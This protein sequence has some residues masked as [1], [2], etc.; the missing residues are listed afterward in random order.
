MVGSPGG[1][2]QKGAPASAAVVAFVLL[3]SLINKFPPQS[4]MLNVG[5]DVK[6]PPPQVPEQ[7]KTAAAEDGGRSRLLPEGVVVALTI[8][9]PLF[10]ILAPSLV[11]DGSS[12]QLVRSLDT[13]ETWKLLSCHLVGQTG[14]YGT[15]EII[16]S[17]L[18][19]PEK[20]FFEKCSL[21]SE[22]CLHLV[23]KRDVVLA[24][25]AAGADAAAAAT[26]TPVPRRLKNSSEE[27][28]AV[29]PF[30]REYAELCPNSS[31]PYN[32]LYKSLH[33]APDVGASLVGAALSSFLFGLWMRR[34]NKKR[35]AVASAASP[36]TRRTEE[37]E[38][39]ENAPVLVIVKRVLPFVKVI[40]LSVSACA[41]L[42]LL[43]NCYMQS[44]AAG[45]PSEILSSIAYG[46]FFQALFNV[47][48]LY[49]DLIFSETSSPSPPLV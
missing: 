33:S 36:G 38:E 6:C 19:T 27:A 49:R 16:R 15:S 28:T 26:T 2:L 40:L 44:S 37:E 30:A 29:Q 1:L 31:L 5:V 13:D 22:E 14:S 43:V 12:L 10:P 46:I 8:V 4:E 9:L 24:L 23:G 39:E 41:L 21:S 42:I 34:K 20:N 45:T 3:G 25:H 47:W 17:L 11:T 48:Y 32:E 35:S 18:V 7:E